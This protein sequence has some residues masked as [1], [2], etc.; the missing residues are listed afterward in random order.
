[1]RAMR[2]TSASVPMAAIFST[3]S[4]DHTAVLWLWKTEDL[5]DEACKRLSYNL[6]MAEWSRYVGNTPYRKTCPN[7]VADTKR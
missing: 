4:H 7:L 5:R 1:M 3:G 2:V 6:T